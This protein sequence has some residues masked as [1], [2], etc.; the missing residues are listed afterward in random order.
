MR[1]RS[2]L[3]GLAAAFAVAT[4]AA[5]VAASAAQKAE[6]V[7]MNQA[8]VLRDSKAGQSIA[9]QIKS[10]TEAANK[11]LTAA[12]SQLQQEA[13]SIQQRAESMSDEEKRKAA[14]TFAAQRQGAAQLQQIKT[15]EI[16]QAE[17]DAMAKLS[18]QLEPVVKEIMKK[19]KAKI[20][21]RRTDVAIMDDAVDIT[22]DVIKALD[23]RVSTISVV[24]PDIQAQL[25][26]QAAQQGGR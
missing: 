7:V 20:V 11:E 13:A 22:D 5:P 10:Y 9:A 19:R 12:G 18:E 24:K 23:K 6:V 15:A 3:G 16:A 21:L 4:T 17:Q 1:L 8:K 25:R 14:Q 26:A 2:L